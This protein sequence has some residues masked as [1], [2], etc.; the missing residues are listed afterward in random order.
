MPARA[1]KP[2]AA[3]AE[4]AEQTKVA[5][6]DDTKA[7]PQEDAPQEK[8]KPAPKDE[9]QDPHIG[10]RVA[11]DVDEVGVSGA[12]VYA[13]EDGVITRKLRD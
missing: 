7:V 8:P 6:P 13:V 3:K 5:A 2:A 1:R 9:A 12:G 10:R 11:G 4:E